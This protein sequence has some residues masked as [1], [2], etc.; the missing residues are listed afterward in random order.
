MIP[1]EWPRQHLA[2]GDPLDVWLGRALHS[3]YSATLPAP[4]PLNLLSLLA[5][6]DIQD[7]FEQRVRDRAYFLRLEEEKP[8]GRELEHW[9]LAFTQQAILK[10]LDLPQ[11]GNEL[12]RAPTA[13]PSRS[14]VALR[15]RL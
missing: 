7:E 15:Y 3:Q 12:P 4:I 6:P 14:K 2:Q 8:K 11:L 5:V 1:P 13:Q 10:S 9:M